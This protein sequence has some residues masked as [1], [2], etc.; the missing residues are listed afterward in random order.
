MDKVSGR[1]SSFGH[2]G[3]A[4]QMDITDKST[5]VNQKRRAPRHPRFK[6]QICQGGIRRMRHCE[7]FFF[8]IL[9]F[10]PGQSWIRPCTIVAAT[11]LSRPTSGRQKWPDIQRLYHRG[12]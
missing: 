4:V 2:P 1:Q 9:N 5:R 6:L 12:S 3:N 11:A 10:D 7:D 8:L